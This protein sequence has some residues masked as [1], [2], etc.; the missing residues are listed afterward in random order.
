MRREWVHCLNQYPSRGHQK[1]CT[2]VNNQAQFF[3]VKSES[4][5][6]LVIQP[7]WRGERQSTNARGGKSPAFSTYQWATPPIHSCSENVQLLHK[8]QTNIAHDAIKNT[9]DTTGMFNFIFM[10]LLKCTTII[11]QNE[12]QF[13]QL[14][15]QQC[16]SA[17][18]RRYLYYSSVSYM[19]LKNI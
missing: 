11:L 12:T 9:A 4:L 17:I 6:H 10:T 3:D 19:L 14:L 1:H 8:N 16:W 5:N 15:T 7:P 18:S 2:H 13:S